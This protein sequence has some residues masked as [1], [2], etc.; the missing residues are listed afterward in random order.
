MSATARGSIAENVKVVGTERG[1]GMGTGDAA[2]PRSLG[3][4]YQ[5]MLTR[6]VSL[7]IAHVGGNV[8]Q[9]LEEVINQTICGKCGPEGYI[10][11]GSAKVMEHSAPMLKA[12]T[13]V[14][15]V[16]FE[17]L[18]CNPVEG[19]I[20]NAVAKNITK[21]GIRAEIPEGANGENTPMVIFISRDHHFQSTA[22]GNVKVDDD[23]QAKIIGVRFMLND[24]YVSAIAQLVE[25]PSVVEKRVVRQR[26]PKLT[27][28]P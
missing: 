16:T 7:S 14:F 6:R 26:K 5:A 9:L 19:M 15:Q 11:P 28:R 24:R 17:C 8:R 10:K 25:R 23:I 21:A 12:D 3:I 18:I 27:M 1:K 22:F 20:V 2:K 4:Y 13:V